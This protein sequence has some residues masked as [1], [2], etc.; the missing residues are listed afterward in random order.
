MLRNM[1]FGEINL[2]QMYAFFVAL[3]VIISIIL[4]SGFI[5][6][7]NVKI[8]VVTI[9]FSLMLL[10]SLAS[11]ISKKMLMYFLYFS[12]FVL[13]YVFVAFFYRIPLLDILSHLNALLSIFVILF[14]TVYATDKKIIKPELLIKISLYS[15]AFFSVFKAIVS[16]GVSNDFFS[17]LEVQLFFENIFKTS[18]IGGIETSFFY[19]FHSPIDYCLPIALFYLSQDQHNLYKPRKIISFLLK[20]LFLLSIVLSY[21]RFLYFY[22]AI[23]VICILISKKYTMFKLKSLIFSIILLITFLCLTDFYSYINDFISERYIGDFAVSS[24]STRYEMFSAIIETFQYSPIFG[25]GLGSSTI[26]YTNIQSMPWYF[27]L[28]WLGFLI[29][30][31][32]AGLFVIIFFAVLPIK[33]FLAKTNVSRTYSI[34]VVLLYVIWLSVG[35]FNGFMTT[36]AGG[37][38]FMFFLCVELAEDQLCGQKISAIS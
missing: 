1:F 25:R 37:V 13:F 5:Y 8:V 23:V 16:F 30:F 10:I 19:R 34:N 38:I 28:Q 11:G 7:F 24:N 4:P 15:L 9:V 17:S 27:E 20:I 12:F 14:S 36:S 31:G 29:Q 6:F 3:L 33:L 21:S 22:S 32:I 26:N 2:R 18:F 35:I